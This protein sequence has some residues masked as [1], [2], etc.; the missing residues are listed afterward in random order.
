MENS[1]IA[2]AGS[3]GTAWPV[4]IR[5]LV[6]IDGRVVLNKSPN[7]FGL[8]YA[9][10]ALEAPFASFVRFRIDVASHGKG[11]LS[12]TDLGGRD[13]RYSRF[14]FTKL[15]FDIDDYDQVWFFADQPNA[16]DGDDGV[17]SDADIAQFGFDWDELRVLALWMQRG[18]GVFAVG[19]H[20]ILGASMCSKI[21]R[22]RT[23]R[24]WRHTQGVPPKSSSERHETLQPV[25]G[26]MDPEGDTV[27][28]PVEV[29]LRRSGGRTP[30]VRS[31]VPHPIMT[32]ATLGLID[33][34]P[35]HMHEGE[36]MADPDVPLDTPLEIPAVGREYPSTAGG[37]RPRPHVIAFGRTTNGNPIQLEPALRTASG[38]HDPG[39][40]PMVTKRFGLVGVYDGD[41]VGLGRVV[42]DSTWH[43]W[44]SL[45]LAGIATENSIAFLKM[46]TYYRNV[47]LWLTTPAQ[48]FSMMISGIWSTLAQ[49][50]PEAFSPNDGPWQ[51]GERVLARLRT[52][53]P[54]GFLDEW[55]A[56]ILDPG[57]AEAVAR[58]EEAAESAP[59]WRSL[60]QEV[61]SRAI[62]GGIGGAL[63]ELVR[64]LRNRRLGGERPRLDP[65][66]I[67]RRAIDGVHRGRELIK[68]TVHDAASAFGEMHAALTRLNEPPDPD[69]QIPLEVRSLRIVVESLQLPDPA[70]PVL[71]N[72]QATITIR[73]LLDDDPLTPG[74]R[75]PNMTFPTFEV[76]AGYNE[77]NRDLGEIQMQTGE[78]LTVEVLVGAWGA[79]RADA[80]AIRFRETLCGDAQSWL[81]CRAPARSH[82]WRLWYRIEDLGPVRRDGE[83]VHTQGGCK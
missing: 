10:E 33:R 78:S 43:H 66:L 42:V 75:E 5:I 37:F 58:P 55:V 27:L 59:S 65:E 61:V 71:R 32:T 4:Q 36:V 29:V 16:Q 35:D 25:M 18:G 3:Y 45:N 47:A 63:V 56:A 20:S 50:S 60:P 21:P 72:G 24:K 68:Q 39:D 83:P 6:V 30:L 64:D 22:V 51:I 57:L 31:L 28:Q 2:A 12:A 67:R 38:P 80:E 73:T 15:G 53:T 82:A 14:E 70:D 74:P 40:L 76:R 23:M 8:G 41:A 13:L 19:D 52:T 48:R 17:T 1:S 46:Q 11:G 54:E 79:Q 34:F 9:L 69:I 77:L 7:M 49:A 81:G 26:P 44:F 62:V